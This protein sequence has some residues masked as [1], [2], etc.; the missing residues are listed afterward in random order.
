MNIPQSRSS[1]IPIETVSQRIFLIRGQKV[2]IDSDLSELYG[3]STIRLNEQVRRNIDRF[4]DDFM[5]QISKEEYESLRSQIAISNSVRGG[6]RYL[7][8][9]FTEHGVSMLS[10]VLK[11]PRAVQLN[12]LIIRAFIRIREILS[13]NKE[14]AYKIEELEREQKVQNRHINAV[15]SMLEKLMSEPTKPKG[16][17]GFSKND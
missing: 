15:Y 12:I 14:L 2:M 11:S 17:I 4:P 10:S 9:A 5:F 3:V 13:S 16:P 7:P 1:I 8:Y 6:R